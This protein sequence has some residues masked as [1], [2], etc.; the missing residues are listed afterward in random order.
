MNRVI[1]LFFIIFSSS[2]FAGIRKELNYS[3]DSIAFYS[4]E[5]GPDLPSWLDQ[6]ASYLKNREKNNFKNLI[7]DVL[8]QM[9]NKNDSLV[10]DSALRIFPKELSQ[11]IAQRAS[12]KFQN[13]PS[14]PYQL[15]ILKKEDMINP[16]RRIRRTVFL[17]YPT[18]DSIHFIFLELNQFIDFQTPY[19]FQDWSNYSLSESKQKQPLEV[20]IPDSAMGILSYFKDEKGESKKFHIVYKTDLSDSGNIKIKNQPKETNSKDAEKRLME[21]KS[22]LDKKLISEEEYKKK[23]AE[24][25][26]SL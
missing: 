2:C 3:S 11:E 7:A 20:F 1:V 12:E 5:S 6:N 26:K 16:G 13:S 24:I 8:F 18:A 22:L 25:L 9:G 17:I 19:T 10:N 21:L 23:R 14:Q 4:F 15:W